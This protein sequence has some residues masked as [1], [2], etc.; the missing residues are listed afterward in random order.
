MAK[1]DVIE[2]L[3]KALGGEREDER[4]FRLWGGRL[5][6]AR[7]GSY[8]DHYFWVRGT[9]ESDSNFVRLIQNTI[10]HIGVGRVRLDDGADLFVELDLNPRAGSIRRPRTNQAVPLAFWLSWHVT[11][12][13]GEYGCMGYWC[14]DEDRALWDLLLGFLT[15]GEWRPLVDH[16]LETDPAF[17]EKWAAFEAARKETA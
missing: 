10:L 12:A 2:R 11:W 17:A 5:K 8:K 13:E 14:R 7:G 1:G 16:L 4:N 3:V 9:T 15:H 6:I